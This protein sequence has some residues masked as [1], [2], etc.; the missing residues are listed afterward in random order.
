MFY[1]KATAFLKARA[2]KNSALEKSFSKRQEKTI[3]DEKNIFFW[4]II[5]Q[6]D[7]KPQALNL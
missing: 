2:R 4:E 6:Q 3:A 1:I 7:M 5:Q